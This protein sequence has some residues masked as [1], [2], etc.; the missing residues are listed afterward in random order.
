[1]LFVF[2]LIWGV[3]LVVNIGSL[4]W[5]VSFGVNFRPL[6]SLTSVINYGEVCLKYDR[7]ED[8]LLSDLEKCSTQSSKSRALCFCLIQLLFEIVLIERT[9]WS[10]FELCSQ[11][12]GIILINSRLGFTLNLAFCIIDIWFISLTVFYSSYIVLI[13]NWSLKSKCTN[14][15]CYGTWFCFISLALFWLNISL[16]LSYIFVASIDMLSELA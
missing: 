6:I 7:E 10:I 12:A 16:V 5:R 14:S 9:L 3:F 2:N 15:D 4:I 13:S 1:M 11:L 8:L